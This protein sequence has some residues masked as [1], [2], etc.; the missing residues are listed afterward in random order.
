MDAIRQDG[1]F[2]DTDSANIAL[3]GG[4]DSSSES[5]PLLCE[6]TDAGRF[7]S[8]IAFNSLENLSSPDRVATNRVVFGVERREA[9]GLAELGVTHEELASSFVAAA[10]VLPVGSLAPDGDDDLQMIMPLEQRQRLPRRPTEPSLLQRALTRS[11]SFAPAT[12]RNFED[13]KS[14]LLQAADEQPQ[15]VPSFARDALVASP[16]NLSSTRLVPL[17]AFAASRRSMMTSLFSLTEDLAS[18]F[19]QPPVHLDG[20]DFT[21]GERKEEH[22]FGA[23]D[24]F[25]CQESLLLPLLQHVETVV[26]VE[27]QTLAGIDKDANVLQLRV[28]VQV[29]LAAYVLLACYIL[30]VSS[31]GVL[32]GYFPDIPPLTLAA[33]RVQCWLLALAPLVAAEWRSMGYKRVRACL[34]I[35]VLRRVWVASLCQLI[36]NCALMV[37]LRMTS[38]ANAFLFN[39]VHSLLLVLWRMVTGAEVLLAEFAGVALGICG[40]IV[41]LAD[42]Q[43]TTTS[44]HALALHPVLGA[45]VALAGAV[46]GACFV[47]LSKNLRSQVPPF[48]FSMLINVAN[49][50]WLV[51]LPLLSGGDVEW[52]A[53][54]RGLF[55]WTQQSMWGVAVFI[56]LVIGIGGGSLSI[57][58]LKVLSPVV[59]AVCALLVPLVAGDLCALLGLSAWPSAQAMLGACVLLLGIACI[60]AAQQIRQISMQLRLVS[61]D[62]QKL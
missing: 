9:Q 50:P 40:A 13:E 20:A 3:E 46:G 36:W 33:W 23:A 53:G 42:H 10:G 25:E 49:L 8:Y 16:S 34:R 61:T 57:V 38:V 4:G 62:P 18:D 45:V 15:Y 29:K 27:P 51:L 7:A 55:G 47:Q 2:W 31:L 41:A 39:N 32:Q 56:G 43:K 21:A 11:I 35:E 37:A 30:S 6:P 59:I 24:D 48:T 58:L 26:E 52:S 60:A 19:E 54:M 17:H 22:G 44:S 28:S 12:Q 1:A 14:L 5:R